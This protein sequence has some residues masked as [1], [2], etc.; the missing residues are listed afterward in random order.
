MKKVLLQVLLMLLF[1]TAARAQTRQ[2]TGK[3]IGKNDETLIGVTIK[4]KGTSTATAT[5]V[6]GAFKLNIPAT[7]NITI[8]AS[9]IGYRA[10]EIGIGPAQKDISITLLEDAATQLNEV[11]VV[12]IGYS[13]IS[14][15]AVVGAVSSVTAKDLVDFPVG[16]AAE[17][18]AGKLA[19][20]S[21]TTTEGKPGADILIRVRGGGSIT[22][23]N[24]P[25]FIVDG[26]QVENA[27]S[28]I[29]PQEIQSIDVLKD[30]AS[31]AIYGSRGANGVVL[32][33]T[34]SGK[35]SR[36][37]VT[38]N[39]YTGI[40][41]ITNE[42]DVMKPY[43]YI[44]YQYQLYNYNTDQQT[45]DAFTKS[46]GTYSDLDIYKNYKFADWQDRV[47]GRNA[48]TQSENVNING[49]SKTASY[50]FTANN[51]K[52]DGIMLNSGNQRTFAA[53]RFDNVASDKFRFG[54][55][56]R[57]SR[58]RVYGAGTSNTG[59]QSNN[60]LRNSVRFRPFEAPGL[61]TQVDQ[62]DPD[63][64]N[65]TNL[66]SPVLGA[67]AVTKNDYTNQVI[68]SINAQYSIIPKLTLS[69]V[70]G[71]TATDR[72]TDQFS[73][74]ITGVARQNA[75]MPVVDLAT[76]STLTIT[77]SNTL[78]YGFNLGKY[79]SIN[80]L[81]GEEINQGKTRSIGNQTKWLPVDITAEQAFAGI[82]KA[83]PP[84]GAVQDPPTTS[85]S[86]TRLFSLFGR[87]S[88]SYREKYLA[89]FIV[90]RDGSSL[91]APENRY[92]VFPSG[93]LG[94][95]VT[96]EDFMKKLDLKWLDNLKL[97][98]SYGAGGNNRIGVDLFKTLYAA[99]SNNG[100]AVDESVT[101]GF[102]PTSFAN[103]NVKWETTISRNLGL[104]FGLFNSRLNASIDVYSNTTKDLLLTS[105]IPSTSGYTT[106]IQN[107]GK[108]SNKGVELQLSGVI[109]NS[110]KFTYNAS[111]NIA[112]NRN[113]IVSLGLDQ[114]GNPKSSYLVASGGVNGNDFIAQ[115]GGP[116]GQ[117]Y[118]YVSDGRYEI[119]DFDITYNSTANTYSY[120]LKAGVADDG[121]AALGAKAPQPG[122]MKLKK[123]SD[124]GTNIIGDADRK[125]LGL[126]QPLFTG[127]FNQQFAFKGFDASVFMNFSYGNKTY[128]ANKT[129]F[130]GQY[131]YKD[132]NM[133]AVV[134]NRWRS[135]DDNGLRVTDPTQLAALNANTTFWTP[136]AGQYILTSYA[137]EDGS[138]LRLTNVT[139]G[140]SLPKKFL[141][142]T[143]V[144]SRFR[145]YATVNNLYT[146]TKYSGYDPEANTRRGNPLTPGVDYAA[147]PR[148]RFV[149]AGIDVSF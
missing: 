14:K 76:S 135:F 93:Q 52:E 33:T 27:L 103:P 139:L 44:L 99:S 109:I 38:L 5:D 72:R 111:F 32:I 4:V 127:G 75:N 41:R 49:G 30:V 119:S 138:F 80:L 15:N 31:T 28:I 136:A 120:K 35:N 79:N 122:D 134:A 62:F 92:A 16:T 148:N 37:V 105:Q 18:L 143:K 107:I 123:L 21:V 70:F 82:Q 51:L 114:F 146:F 13:T 7:G 129:E 50:N 23:D 26:V 63:Y 104:D 1:C 54:F 74:A 2:L 66:T 84:S 124:N 110:K 94:W 29:S 68:S 144:F 121:A 133:L 45:K 83:T 141:E 69:T 125:V 43:D 77:N 132:N 95:R 88:Y 17:A 130:T 131:L 118:G 57:Y 55:N 126:T 149:L 11:A 61:E 47:F 147:Y 89:S 101:P 56:T 140:Y 64:A 60:Q 73:S 142:R 96:E 24:S 34:K 128:N 8:V 25:L 40:R 71:I 46:Y 22:Q 19:G 78:S 117:I 98:V 36:T 65:L 59:S 108:T 97:R 100:Y 81:A 115:V 90:R 6:N 3:V 116:V 53:F 86:G 113:K 9:Y 12:N 48:I 20:V 42:L 58:Q 85:E 145:V 137:I 102:A 67:Y 106:Q 112:F 91:F 10:Q 39:G 87:A